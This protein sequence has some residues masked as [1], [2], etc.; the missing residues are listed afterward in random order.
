MYPLW[1]MK[2]EIGNNIMFIIGNTCI[3]WYITMYENMIVLCYDNN[4]V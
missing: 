3:S 4:I 1:H 2:V